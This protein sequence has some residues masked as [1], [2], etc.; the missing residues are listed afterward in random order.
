MAREVLE[1]LDKKNQLLLFSSLDYD[2]YF[3]N[4]IVDE[5]V[6]VEKIVETQIMIESV[7]V[8]IY[9]TLI[10]MIYNHLRYTLK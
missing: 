1:Q 5:S 7:R 8:A 3:I 9:I 4:N 2:G 6:Y 10:L